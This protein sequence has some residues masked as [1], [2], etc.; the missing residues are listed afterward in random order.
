MSRYDYPDPS[1]DPAYCD[2]LA[3]D[4][5]RDDR[6]HDDATDIAQAVE[7]SIRLARAQEALGMALADLCAIGRCA[8]GRHQALLL[9]NAL[10]RGERA[11]LTLTTA[12][13]A[14]VNVA[15]VLNDEA[16]WMTATEAEEW[17]RAAAWVTAA[18]A[19]EHR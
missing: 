19:E 18:E 12:A 13:G 14:R 17:A 16:A 9:W 2:G 6:E 1:H 10:R 8:R 3:A 11:V 5:P 7:F 15:H 4:D